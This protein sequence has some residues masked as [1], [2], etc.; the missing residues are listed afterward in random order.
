[1][2]A[3]TITAQERQAK[4]FLVRLI[5]A[6]NTGQ[7]ESVNSV[8]RRALRGR[9][10]ERV[11]MVAFIEKMIEADD[12]LRIVA[13]TVSSLLRTSLASEELTNALAG[14]PTAGSDVDDEL[15]TSDD[16]LRIARV[17]GEAEASILRQPMVESSALAR[18]LGSSSSNP[19]EF[20][21]S[22]RARGDV[23][24]LPRPSGNA[25]PAFQVDRVRG[26]VWPIVV[27]INHLLGANEDPWG[28]A[29]WWFTVDPTLETEPYHVV[30]DPTR[31]DDLRR[32]AR[33]A[34]AAVE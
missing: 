21:R 33:A 2:K 13:P 28:A 1:M 3:T 5:D 14:T 22:A 8:L 24:G 6:V 19:R 31:A 27:E 32:A 15:L 34:L 23:I 7:G 30:S 17:R 18:A 20:A 4:G 12:G 10:S 26:E 25:F 29:S 9:R 16:V 11:E